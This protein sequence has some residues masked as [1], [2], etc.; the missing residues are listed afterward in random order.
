MASLL[1]RLAKSLSRVER[2]GT[3]IGRRRRLAAVLCGLLVLFVRAA[4]LPRLPI[5]EPSIHDEFSY[6]LAADTFASGRLT[7]T[8]HPMWEHFESFHIIQ[9]PTYM[10][11]YPPGQGLV[12]A[13]GQVLFGHPWWGVFLSTGLFCCAL[14]WMLQGWLPP[15]WAFL[16]GLLMAMRIG[17]FSGF[18]NS[19]FGTSLAGIGGAL[20]LGALPRI[21]QHPRVRHAVYMALGLA[22]LANTRPFE[23]LVLSIPVAGALLFWIVARKPGLRVSITKI[24]LP[25][26]LVLLPAALAT[27]YYCWRLTQNPFQ[28][29]YL[30]NRE[31]YA[32]TPYFLWQSLRPEPVYRHEVMRKFYVEWEPRF[33]NAIGQNSLHGWLLAAQLKVSRAW[34]LGFAL[35][36]PLIALPCLFKD[37][38]VR[39][40]LLS[41]PVML[42]GLA[43][44]RYTQPRYL[45]P[46]AGAFSVI[47]LQS[48]RHMRQ[49]RVRGHQAGLLLVRAVCFV[50]CAAFLGQAI[51]TYPDAP[52]PGDLDRAQILRHLESLP[53]RQLAIVRYTPDHS[54]LHE[55]VYNRADIDHAKVVWAREMG[56]P[57]DQQLLRYFRDRTAWL[58]EPDQQPPRLD[59]YIPPE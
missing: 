28:M 7:N 12:L 26:A 32:V 33:Q 13:A 27:C 17:V 49:W 51:I 44:E 3:S 6:L 57:D 20:V 22:I 9:F 4:E 11:M 1:T 45:I 39:F 35:T 15:G 31:T 24:A 59:P 36:L 43:L 29:P 56:S 34:Y 10:S 40:F 42:I 41:A 38:R 47:V 58:V 52:Y 8:T 5:P 48:M 30:L 46:M 2:F 19:Y 25:V 18:M 21:I 14:C 16:G 54:V 37:R 23:G 53:G 50:C 55:W